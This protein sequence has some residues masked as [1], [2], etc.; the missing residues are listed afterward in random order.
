MYILGRSGLIF[1]LLNFQVNGIAKAEASHST[2]EPALQIPRAVEP[3]SS[4]GSAGRNSRHVDIKDSPDNIIKALH[5][6]DA[7]SNHDKLGIPTD[8]SN[9][10]PAQKAKVKAELAKVADALKNDFKSDLDF[11]N[12]A[13]YLPPIPGHPG[14]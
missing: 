6:E 5:K 12:K 2:D 8:P 4:R 7:A 9:L 10:S 11:A 1:F 14:V 13:G 3:R